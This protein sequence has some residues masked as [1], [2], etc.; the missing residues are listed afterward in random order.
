MDIHITT[1]YD[2]TEANS[3]AI[4][5]PGEVSLEKSLTEVA[6]MLANPFSRSTGYAYRVAHQYTVMRNAKRA[7]VPA[8]AYKTYL[9]A[10]ALR[11]LTQ[12]EG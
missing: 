2:K 11:M 4:G 12:G 8:G 1:M 5:M 3:Y 9:D 7:W 6:D 10:A